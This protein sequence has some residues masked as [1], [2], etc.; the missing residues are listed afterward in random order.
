VIKKS[1]SGG[2]GGDVVGKRERKRKKQEKKKKEKEKGRVRR[3]KG[4]LGQKI[5]RLKFRV[6]LLR[7]V[8]SAR[9]PDAPGSP[10]ITRRH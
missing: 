1:D 10:A 3:E 5:P 4:V 9:G 6:T 7:R 8:M 2:E